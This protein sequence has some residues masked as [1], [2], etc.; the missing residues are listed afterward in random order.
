[1]NNA[2]PL[3]SSSS[4]RLFLSALVKTSLFL[5]YFTPLATQKRWSTVQVSQTFQSLR[6]SSARSLIENG[7]HSCSNLA[8]INLRLSRSSIIRNGFLGF[9]IA[10]KSY[11]L[12]LNFFIVV[13]TVEQGIVRY[14]ETSLYVRIGLQKLVSEPQQQYTILLWSAEVSLR[15]D[16][17]RGSNCLINFT[18]LGLGL[19]S[20]SS[21]S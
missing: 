17:T 20:G 15:R 6:I 8:D 16:L 11:P 21:N 4:S 10:S 3:R 7:S 13:S 1:M 12:A 5:K 2:K 19:N 18:L 9:I 14:F